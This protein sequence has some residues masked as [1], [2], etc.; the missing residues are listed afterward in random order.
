[1]TNTISKKIG[2][3]CCGVAVALWFTAG[4]LAHDAWAEETTGTLSIHCVKDDRIL[5]GMH[6]RIYKVGERDAGEFKFT[7]DFA[8]YHVT[9]GE[10]DEN[11]NT[12]DAEVVANVAETL[13]NYA[14]V[15]ELPFI[16]EGWTNENGI[17][18]FTGLENGLYLV[19]GDEYEQGAYKYDPSALFFEMD[20]KEEANLNAF[21][22]VETKTGNAVSGGE[23]ATYTV[24]KIWMND[25]NQ[26]WNRAVSITVAIYK[27]NKYYEQKVLSQENDWQ[28]SW[29]GDA[30]AKWIVIEREV[31]SGYSVVVK[32][33]EK[34]YLIVNTHDDIFS[35]NNNE[36][37]ISTTTTPMGGYEQQTGTSEINGSQ[38]ATATTAVTGGHETATVTQTTFNVTQQF[39]TAET[40]AVSG[41]ATTGSISTTQTQAGGQTTAL[42]TSDRTVETVRKTVQTTS[43]RTITGGGN[44]GNNGG[45]GG[46]SGGGSGKLPQTGQLWFPVPFLSVGG[47]FFMGMGLHLRKKENE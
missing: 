26:L 28:Y 33:N 45:S 12:W 42:R 6:W 46:N 39:S 27:D 47:M 22:K 1:M 43:A 20:S 32:K 13:R 34:N 11:A 37:R 21:P 25:E 15:D 35:G 23:S 24:K 36:T 8:N 19:C 40:T 30:Q 29:V 14:D 2:A 31:P 9:F 16:D 17:L 18:K 44:G 5:D 7:D 4:V 38:T 10:V 3:L 41:T